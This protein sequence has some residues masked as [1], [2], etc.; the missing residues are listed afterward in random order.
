MPLLLHKLR[1][2]EPC[3]SSS[4][5]LPAPCCLPR[6]CP[7]TGQLPAPDQSS[8]H[9]SPGLA[10]PRLLLGVPWQA[11]RRC[12]YHSSFSLP[13]RPKRY[14][15]LS[16][17]SPGTSWVG[18]CGFFVPSSPCGSV[19]CSSLLLC[20]VSGRSG[21]RMQMGYFLFHSRFR[22]RQG[23]QRKTYNTESGREALGV[24]ARGQPPAPKGSSAVTLASVMS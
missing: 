23:G 5:S 12:W 19:P 17:Q 22:A 20:S 13:V 4:T 16:L 14:R 9:V 21:K 7:G 10:S 8:G 18:T 1:A 3:P 2:G 15:H 24:H 6:A 11:R